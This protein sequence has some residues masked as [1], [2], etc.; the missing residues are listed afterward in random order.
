MTKPPH[1]PSIVWV[2]LLILGMIALMGGIMIFFTMIATVPGFASVIFLIIG[3][4]YVFTPA[5]KI[6][7]KRDLS[8]FSGSLAQAIGVGFF[9]LM[10]MAIDQPGNALYNYPL[11]YLC[12]PES[13]MY[14]DVNVSHPLPGRTDMTQDFRC[15]NSHGK[16]VV[17]IG[18]GEVIV[19][20]FF[21]YLILAYVF[22]GLKRLKE[23]NATHVVT[24][25]EQ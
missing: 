11:N 25:S 20:R 6:I 3:F 14:R 22:I 16:L 9:A 7:D 17:E 10:G 2:F 13:K 24:Q 19:V 18:M 15:L 4:L 23:K 5:S 21:E 1:L 12:P 8:T